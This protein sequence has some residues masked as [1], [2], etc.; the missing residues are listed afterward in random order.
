MSEKKKILVSG[1]VNFE[2]TCAVRGFPVEYA[3]IDFHFFGVKTNVSGVGFN[4]TKALT[5]LECNVSLVTL[6][7]SDL[8]GDMA[9]R[10]L[11]NTGA[12]C[13]FVTRPLRETPASTVLYDP[14]G[15]RRIYCDLKDIQ[16]TARDVSDIDLTDCAAAVVCNINFS[17]PLLHKAKAAGI[18]IVTDVHT[19][20]HPDD[21]YN[22]EF[23]ANAD[24][25]FLSDESLPCE[26]EAFVR[27]LAARYGCRL[28]VM[29]C[30]RRGALLYRRDT[31][32]CL[33]QPATPVGKVINTVGAGDALLSAF[34]SQWV[35]GLPPEEC[36]RRAQLFAAAKITQSGASSG[37]LSSNE[38]E[39]LAASSDP[40]L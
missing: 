12:D 18:P 24:L 28:I 27:Q 20:H 23:M 1:L 19:L 25:L 37:F 29:G 4:I 3:P 10:E 13:R 11:Q 5:A 16:E 35:K 33:F 9:L 40:T 38:L 30:G 15:R 22:R 17:R 31:D 2:T 39:A 32:A 7:G 26:P 6:L 8:A 34:V 36:L 21:D 14:D